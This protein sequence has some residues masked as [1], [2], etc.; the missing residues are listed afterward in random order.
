MKVNNRYNFSRVYHK[1][2]LV[3][4]LPLVLSLRMYAC[5]GTWSARCF[6][7]T[8]DCT[9]T[10]PNEWQFLGMMVASPSGIHCCLLVLPALL[11]STSK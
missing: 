9:L 10:H 3:C 11:R 6:P 5:L 4:S 8:W 1:E 7:E 2:V